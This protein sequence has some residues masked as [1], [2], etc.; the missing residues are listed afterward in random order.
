MNGKKTELKT[1]VQQLVSSAGPFKTVAAKIE[2]LLKTREAYRPRCILSVACPSG[3]YLSF[4]GRGGGRPCPGPVRGGAGQGTL[5]WS[6]SGEMGGGG[7]PVLVL[8]GV[9]HPPVNY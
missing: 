6:W 8:A 5:S 4:G 2:A 3:G 1:R 7:Y 9:Y